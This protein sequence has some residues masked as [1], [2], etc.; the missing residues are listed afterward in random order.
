MILGG[1]RSKSSMGTIKYL[2]HK[3]PPWGN[4]QTL[5]QW[6]RVLFYI[7]TGQSA[8]TYSKAMLRLATKLA[9]DF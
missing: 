7:P 2:P 1:A 5:R 4:L 3:T 8:T 9:H 6:H